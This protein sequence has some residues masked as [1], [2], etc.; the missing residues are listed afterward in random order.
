MVLHFF[1]HHPYDFLPHLQHA[2]SLFIAMIKGSTLSRAPVKTGR[3]CDQDY[4]MVQGGEKWRAFRGMGRGRT[5]SRAP[6]K[7]GPNCD[8]DYMMVQ[9]GE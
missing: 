6:V 4:M 3:N 1:K 9:G 2:H 5:L 7:T 8:Q